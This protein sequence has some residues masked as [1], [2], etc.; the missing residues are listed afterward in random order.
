MG[1]ASNRKWIRRQMRVNFR[2]TKLAEKLWLTNLFGHMPRFWRMATV[3]AGVAQVEREPSRP[4]HFVLRKT[5]KHGYGHAQGWNGWRKNHPT[6]PIL[7]LMARVRRIA[8][9]SDK[10]RLWMK[11]ENIDAVRDKV[12]DDMR[13][14]A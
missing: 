1:R 10:R 7:E 11:R 12:E 13:G 5:V 9:Q 2:K 6:V 14:G 4:V 8:R 3:S